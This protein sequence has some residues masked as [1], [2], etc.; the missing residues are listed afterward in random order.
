MT[1]SFWTDREELGTYTMLYANDVL[2]DDFNISLDNPDCTHPELSQFIITKAE[3]LQLSIRNL[4][5]ESIDIGV[6]NLFSVSTG[7]KI[8]PAAT[9]EIFVDRSLDDICT[10]VYVNWEE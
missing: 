7:L 5:G 9:G 8:K 10:L 4:E 2:I 1:L 6:I 3:D